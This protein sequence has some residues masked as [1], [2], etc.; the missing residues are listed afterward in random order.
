MHA[1]YTGC[2]SDFVKQWDASFRNT[3]DSYVFQQYFYCECINIILWL[4]VLYQAAPLQKWLMVVVQKVGLARNATFK[5]FILLTQHT[6]IWE[7]QSDC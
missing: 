5:F 2:S 1:M 7:D 3:P 6:S 4:L